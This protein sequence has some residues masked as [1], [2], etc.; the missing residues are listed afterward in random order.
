M[1]TEPYHFCV[2]PGSTARICISK[3]GLS[4]KQRDALPV[5]M[6]ARRAYNMQPQGSP[7]PSTNRGWYINTPV[8]TPLGWE[9]IQNISPQFSPPGLMSVVPNDSCDYTLYQ[10]SSLPHIISLLPGLPNCLHSI[11]FSGSP[12]GRNKTKYV[13]FRKKEFYWKHIG[14]S[15]NWEHETSLPQL[16][17]RQSSDTKTYKADKGL[18]LEEPNAHNTVSLTEKQSLRDVSHGSIQVMTVPVG[19]SQKT[20]NNPLGSQSGR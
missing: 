16:G 17:N 1:P 18:S 14:G 2:N 3:W 12:S 5:L 20:E 6:A 15:K 4:S 19:T 10:L 7:Q 13:A 9:L 8:P 11:P